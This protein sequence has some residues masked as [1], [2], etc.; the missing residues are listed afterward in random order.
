MYTKRTPIWQPGKG[1]DDALDHTPYVA[2]V[3]EQSEA[4][5]GGG[6]AGSAGGAGGN[7]PGE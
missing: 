6:P 4:I 2:L 5:G 3:D 1:F 7:A